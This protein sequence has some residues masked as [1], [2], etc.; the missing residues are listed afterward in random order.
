M[1]L[2]QLLAEV[3]RCAK[4][5]ENEHNHSNTQIKASYQLRALEKGTL[6]YQK[7]SMVSLELQLSWI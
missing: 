6:V 3:V 2:Y 5:A 7:W 4:C 1:Q